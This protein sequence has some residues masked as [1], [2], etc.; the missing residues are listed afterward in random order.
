[1]SSNGDGGRWDVLIRGGTVFDGSGAAPRVGDVAIAGQRIAARGA[2]LPADGADRVIDAQGLWVMPGLID[3]H[4]HFDLEVEIAPGLPEA[5]RHGT[6]T[7]VVANCSLGLAFGAQRTNG[8]DPIVDCFARVEN[9]PKHVLK[10]VADQATW[11]DSGDYLTHLDTLPL[12]ANVVPMVPHSMLRIEVMGLRDSISRDPDEAELSRMEALLDKAMGEGYAGFSTDALPFH[13]L[14]NDPNRRKK[15]PAQ[16]G[17]YAELKRLTSI[18]RR[19]DRVWQATPPKDQPLAIL[20][21]FLLTSGRLHGRPLR[22]TA[23]AALDVASNRGTAKLGLFLARLLNSR[24][25]GGRFALQALAAPFKVW[26]EG[27][28]TPLFEEIPELRELNEPDLEDRAARRAIL[29]DADYAR[30]FRRMWR[31]GKHGIGPARWRRALSREE[32]AFARD[33]ESM[34]VERCP[35]DAWR[36]ESLGDIYRRV[37]DDQRGVDAARDDQ[38][39]EALAAFPNP[40]RDDADFMLHMLRAYDT[41]L[42]WYSVSANRDQ[43]IVRDLLMHPKLLPGFNDS[44]AHLTNMAFYDGNLRA[45]KIAAAEGDDAV[46]YTV[47]RLTRVPAEFFNLERGRIEAGDVADVTV[48]DPRALADYDAEANVRSVYRKEFE[49]E[50]LVNRSDGVVPFVFVGGQEAWRG[51]DFGADLGK[52]KMGAALRASA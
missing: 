33:I 47:S 22:V 14:A 24:L 8:A 5:V 38:E 40:L 29:D 13:Y 27:P 12:G 31:K 48:V 16:F 19:H 42:Y 39:A 9:I 21:N 51:D 28:I 30:R 3:V 36:G 44:G 1:M 7:A 45:L 35:V 4:T 32:L 6:T 52:R 20:R 34:F 15:I 25:V 17:S 18:L 46:A 49:H 10:K 50:Q 2:N 37:L 26:G 41:D 23:V 11:S 43:A